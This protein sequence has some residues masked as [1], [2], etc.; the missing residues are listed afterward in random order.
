MS[1][2][3]ESYS[4]SPSVATLPSQPVEASDMHVLLRGVGE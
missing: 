1:Q 3:V 4:R 2:R